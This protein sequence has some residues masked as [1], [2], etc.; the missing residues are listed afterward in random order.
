MPLITVECSQ[1]LIIVA[2][3][4][5]SM[6]VTIAVIPFKISYLKYF[7]MLVFTLCFAIAYLGNSKSSRFQ[8]FFKIVVLRH[9]TNFTEKLLW[10]SLFLIKLQ[11]LSKKRIWHRC[12][13]WNLRNFYE[14]L[15]LQKS[16]D[17]YFWNFFW[18]R[19]VYFL[20]VTQYGI[21]KIRLGDDIA[22]IFT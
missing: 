6:A 2:F 20:L 7:A 18:K 10:W 15:F 19:F 9:F 8:V 16:S 14:Q 13:L 21:Y 12:F 1:K 4:C 17:G 3:K 5:S 22:T 11:A